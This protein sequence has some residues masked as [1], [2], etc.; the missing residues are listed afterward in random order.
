M[1]LCIEG[2]YVGICELHIAN[3]LADTTDKAVAL[4]AVCR[5]INVFCHNGTATIVACVHS[6]CKGIELLGRADGVEAIF[7]GIGVGA[8]VVIDN[9]MSL[10]DGD[11]VLVHTDI[12]E[13]DAV[14]AALAVHPIGQFT[15]GHLRGSH[16]GLLPI[17]VAIVDEVVLVV[18]PLGS[19][20]RRQLIEAVLCNH[21][22][23]VVTRHGAVLLLAVGVLRLEG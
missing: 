2:A 11:G 7:V 4:G 9:A 8:T 5:V 15:I 1:T 12:L 17:L 14:L 23:L 18:L 20:L 6:L 3:L 16:H 22:V 13:V 19:P 10:L 21:Q